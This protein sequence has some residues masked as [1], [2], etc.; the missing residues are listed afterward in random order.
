VYFGDDKATIRIFALD[1]L[2]VSQAYDI[3]LREVCLAIPEMKKMATK[4]QSE[5]Y[6]V[7]DLVV[8]PNNEDELLIGFSIGLLIIWRI[9]TREVSKHCI[10]KR[11][12]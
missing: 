4:R 2:Q 5:E 7:V 10:Y 12:S 3:T 1:S 9:S 11:V 8:N 6:S